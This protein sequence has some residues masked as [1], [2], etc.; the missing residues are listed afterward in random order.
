S[1]YRRD[2][3]P[4][5]E[6]IMLKALARDPNERF[7]TAGE[8]SLALDKIAST[9]GVG[10]S[11]TALANYM[12]LQ[13]GEQKEPW[14]EAKEPEPDE[15]TDESEVTAVDFDGGASGLA[16]PPTETVQ[17]NALPRAMSVS[18]DAPIVAARTQAMTPPVASEKPRMPLPA[19]NRGSTQSEES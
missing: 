3:P 9:V 4:Q 6:E 12:R 18:K 8:M 11:T 7:A 10:A 2:I 17:K 13:F 16:P 14:L 19:P 5:L 1:Q 15:D